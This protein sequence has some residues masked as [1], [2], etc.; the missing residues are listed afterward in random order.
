MSQVVYEELER[1]I[2]TNELRP[3]EHLTEMAL[4]ARFKTSRTSVREALKQLELRELVVTSPH[5]GATVREF[6]KDE[7]EEVYAVR[8]TLEEMAARLAARNAS[9]QAVQEIE[10]WAQRFETACRSKNLADMVT[11]NR[12]FHRGIVRAGGNRMLADVVDDLCR[13]T[14]LVRSIFWSSQPNVEQSMQ[15]HAEMITAL[16]Q[17]DEERLVKLTLA[18]IHMGR[19]HYLA[20]VGRL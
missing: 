2:L 8:A 18:H 11:T 7:L 17:R 15:A 14:F 1:A 16:R 5:R 12:S 3:R 10:R 4:A 6:T 19:E 20:L 9:P 13:R